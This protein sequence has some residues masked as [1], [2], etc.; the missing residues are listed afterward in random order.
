MLSLRLTPI[1][2][3]VRLASALFRLPQSLNWITQVSEFCDISALES[4]HNDNSTAPPPPV[5]AAAAAPAS[6]PAFSR[7]TVIATGSDLV[8]DLPPVARLRP[9][10]LKATSAASQVVLDLEHVHFSTVFMSPR[11]PV[12]QY[13][14]SLNTVRL[15]CARSSPPYSAATES[16]FVE[17]LSLPR[18]KAVVA[19]VTVDSELGAVAVSVAVNEIVTSFCADSLATF[20]VNLNNQQFL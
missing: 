10:P 15:M 8:V 5:A 2:C 11:P 1:S 14:A 20:Q 18:E 12:Q 13:S 4:N 9:A 19:K 3:K 7:L 17:L 16:N 6:A